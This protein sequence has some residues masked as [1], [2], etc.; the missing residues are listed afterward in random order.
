MTNS[1]KIHYSGRY[2]GLKERDRWEHAY[3][4]NA[5]GVVVIVPV[6]DAGEIVLVEQYRIPVNSRVLEYRPDWWAITRTVTRISK[7]LPGGNC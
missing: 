6:T 7:P 3:R 2:L 4:T 1:E 5:R